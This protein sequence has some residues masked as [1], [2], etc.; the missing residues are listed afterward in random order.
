MKKVLVAGAAGFIGRNLCA[1]LLSTG[2]R[3]YGIDNLS[4]GRRE[5]ISELETLDNFSFFQRDIAQGLIE[6]EADEI[7][8]LACVASPTLYQKEPIHTLNTCYNGSQNLLELARRNNARILLAS[9]SE[10]YGEPYESPQK[11]TS[12]GN[13][14]PIGVRSCYDEGKRVAEALFSAYRREY[15]VDIRIARI[16]NTY[17]I[18]MNSN[19]GRVVSNFIRQALN[20]E[21]ITIYGSGK[22]TRSF[23]YVDDTVNG[24][25]ALMS[26]EETLPVN[27]GNPEEITVET[28]ANKILRLT[29]STSRVIFQELPEDDP[30]HRQPDITRAID[31][32]NWR[33]TVSL[34]EGLMRTIKWARKRTMSYSLKTTH[35]KNSSTL[36]DIPQ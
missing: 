4:S 27:I 24:L 19:D 11:E 25:I 3:V 15:D 10:I 17:G 14:N 22:Q 31:L 29:G 21:P 1:K 12:F 36:N 33:P 6:F 5:R 16:F 23:C 13:V 2:A 34:E 28:L 7:Y 18:G 9:T 30:T 8:N 20:S 32:L 35:S 26:S